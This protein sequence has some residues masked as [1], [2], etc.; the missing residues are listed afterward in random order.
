MI[1]QKFFARADFFKLS[2][3]LC[4]ESIGRRILKPILRFVLPLG[5][6]VVKED[7]YENNNNKFCRYC[8]CCRTKEWSESGELD[9]HHQLYW[10]IT[11]TSK[12]IFVHVRKNVEAAL[13][14]C[15][16][17]WYF[18]KTGN[19]IWV[20]TYYCAVLCMYI[21]LHKCCADGDKKTSLLRLFFVCL[22]TF[23]IFCII[24][25]SCLLLF[26]FK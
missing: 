13:K 15:L 9:P 10:T 14:I 7:D 23:K 4:D 20:C 21:V 8:C 5:S 24:I 12:A 25:F 22:L 6:T 18:L 26:F 2:G 16:P 17:A 11:Q 1:F 19:W 3:P